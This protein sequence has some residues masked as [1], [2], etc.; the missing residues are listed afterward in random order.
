MYRKEL[1]LI[2]AVLSISV[3][4]GFGLSMVPSAIAQNEFGQAAKNTAPLGEHS[5][6]GSEFTGTAPYDTNPITE[7]PDKTGRLGIGNIGD[8]VCGERITPGELA[9]F[10]D[11]GLCPGQ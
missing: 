10:L 4:V 1:T 5:R 9:R 11:T 7:E 3:S 2:A 6:E 8:T